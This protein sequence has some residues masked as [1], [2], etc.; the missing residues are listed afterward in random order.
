MLRLDDGGLVETAGIGTRGT[1]A[2]G[3]FREGWRQA[4]IGTATAIRMEHASWGSS[5]HDR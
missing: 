2:L 1:V 3:C 5:V 4:F